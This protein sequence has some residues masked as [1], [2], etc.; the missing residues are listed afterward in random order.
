MRGRKPKPVE[1]RV[2]HGTAA[3]RAQA[4]YPKPRRALPRCPEHLTGE[5]EKCWRR[6]SRE[7]YDAGLLSTI[8]REALAAY[9][10]AYARYRKAEDM[11]AETSEVILTA[12]REDEDGTKT[13]GNLVQNPWLAVSNRALDQ[14]T[15]LAA[16]FGMTPSSRSRVKAEISA[17]RQAAPVRERHE[18]GPASDDDPRKALESS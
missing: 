6:L 15:K 8:D 13:G 3:E 11:L 5:A 2:L 10:M 4:A 1:L 14:M 9:C 7:L 17:A 18:R 16:E 12:Q